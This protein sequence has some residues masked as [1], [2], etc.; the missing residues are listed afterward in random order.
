MANILYVSDLDG[1][2]LRSS[3]RTSEYTNQ[4]I[5]EILAKGIPFSYATARSVCTARE[6]TQGIDA[7]FPVIAYNGVCLMDSKSCEIL[8]AQY[9]GNDVYPLFTALFAAGIYPT[10]YAMIAG[11][12]RFS[13]LPSKSS[14]ATLDFIATRNDMRKRTVTTEEELIAGNVFYITCIEESEKLEPFYQKYKD[15]FHCIYQKDIYSGEQWLEILPKCASKAGAVRTLKQKLGCDY[16]IAFGDGINDLEMFTLADEAY[17][18]QNAVPELKAIASGIIG[19]NNEDGVAH[20]LEENVLSS[21][22]LRD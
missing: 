19:S 17:A 7:H 6:V 9:F 21:L 4:I 14:R 3:Q 12:E 1:T 10:V 15:Q 11:K 18:V 22:R 8:E 16:V 13:N 20:W 2:L 5:N